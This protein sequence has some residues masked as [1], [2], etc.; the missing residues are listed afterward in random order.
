MQQTKRIYLKTD[1]WL[2]RLDHLKKKWMKEKSFQRN[3]Q[4]ETIVDID[5]LK[6]SAELESVNTTWSAHSK[7]ILSMKYVVDLFRLLLSPS[8]KQKNAC[9]GISFA[10]TLVWW[11]AV[12]VRPSII[13]IVIAMRSANCASVSVKPIGNC[14]WH[15]INIDINVHSFTVYNFFSRS[16]SF[17][18]FFFYLSIS[19]YLF[20][21]SFIF[22]F[23]FLFSRHSFVLST[24]PIAFVVCSQCQT[25]NSLVCII[26]KWCTRACA[27]LPAYLWPDFQW[28]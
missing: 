20:V 10:C 27:R 3:E 12:A 25:P 9:I 26:A 17:P 16:I 28:N 6:H 18:F 5:Y 8:V 2:I 22:L 24:D 23:S 19:G 21:S 7:W 4:G 11:G 14:L 15:C 1:I 13:V